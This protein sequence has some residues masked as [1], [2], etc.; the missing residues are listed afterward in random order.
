MS[1][2]MSVEV[3]LATLVE[4]TAKARKTTSGSIAITLSNVFA[5]P[6]GAR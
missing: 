3:E 1:I 5:A 6:L 4:I 2:A